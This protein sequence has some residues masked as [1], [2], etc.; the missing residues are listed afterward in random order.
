MEKKLTEEQVQEIIEMYKSKKSS[1]EISKK[2]EVSAATI[3]RYLKNN[4]ISIRSQSECNRKKE[5]D[6]NFFES[7]DTEEKVYWLGYIFADG[8]ISKRTSGKKQT[9]SYTLSLS[10]IDLEQIEKFKNSIKTTSAT[11]IYQDKKRGRK[12]IAKIEINSEKLVVDLENLGCIERKT[13]QLK[14]PSEEQVP[15]ELLHHFI[16]GYFDGDGS[17]SKTK[18]GYGRIDICGIYS[19]LLD[20]SNAF[21]F[22]GKFLYRDKRKA[23][24]CWNLKI[25]AIAK[26][27]Y[28]YEFMYKDA[29][30]YMNRKFD[31]F[32][33]IYE[34]IK[35]RGSETIISYPKELG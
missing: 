32:K 20:L 21:G 33:T 15:K 1:Y 23:T 24:D 27:E 4:S 12:P 19:F 3:L 8:S 5:V 34:N 10:S 2:F 28:L 31:K 29:T 6:D 22:E 35:Q 17:V 14:F 18:I 11:N 13:F 26:L 7:I 25:A 16:R 9:I 30:I